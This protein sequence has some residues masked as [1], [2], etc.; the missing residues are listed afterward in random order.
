MPPHLS[1]DVEVVLLVL[2]EDGEELEECAV[3][4][5]SHTRLVCREP[6]FA[7]GETESRTNLVGEGRDSLLK[8]TGNLKCHSSMEGEFTEYCIL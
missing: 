3:E 4:V 1:S 5:V 8:I 2:V 7:I 6:F